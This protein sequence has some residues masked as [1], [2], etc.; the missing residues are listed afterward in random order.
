MLQHSVSEEK[1]IRKDNEKTQLLQRQ[2]QPSLN[3]K[4]VGVGYK[5]SSAPFQTIK[6]Q[7]A[8]KSR[9]LKSLI[10]LPSCQITKRKLNVNLNGCSPWKGKKLHL[11]GMPQPKRLN[12]IIIP[13]SG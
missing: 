7:S 9:D 10:P 8:S 6:H 4:L 11:Y 13:F 3:P 1:T 12:L 2:Q 5:D